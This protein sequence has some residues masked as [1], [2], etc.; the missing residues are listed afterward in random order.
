MRF[1]TKVRVRLSSPR[2]RP[3]RCEPLKASFRLAE[4]LTGE[5]DGTN[6]VL[7]LAHEHPVVETEPYDIYVDDAPLPSDAE[8]PEERVDGQHGNLYL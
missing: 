5:T 1:W 3:G 6:R 4:R 7:P 8:R 2:R